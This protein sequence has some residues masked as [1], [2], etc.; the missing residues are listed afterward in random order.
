MAASWTSGL[1]TRQLPLAARQRDR[2]HSRKW[3]HLQPGRRAAP[4]CRDGQRVRGGRG[5]RAP[6]RARARPALPGVCARLEHQ[7][8]A[9]ADRHPVPPV[10][11]QGRIFA[12]H[13]LLPGER[14]TDPPHDH[15]C[16]AGGRRLHDRRAGRG[17]DR[18]RRGSVPR[19]PQ[20]DNLPAGSRPTAGRCRSSASHRISS[21]STCSPRCW[22]RSSPRSASSRWE[23][24]HALARV[25]GGRDRAGLTRR[26]AE[27]RGQRRLPGR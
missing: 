4:A 12:G 22:A 6:P 15:G 24:A 5:A 20:H 8:A 13:P 9:G 18:E 21:T 27:A 2:A 10:V 14:D 17:R 11:A 26:F 1:P 19:N 3:A 16:S 23:T 7:R 25:Q